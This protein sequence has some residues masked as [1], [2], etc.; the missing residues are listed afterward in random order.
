M[1]NNPQRAPTHKT[2]RSVKCKKLS[3]HPNQLPLT[4]PLS[5]ANGPS[6]NSGMKLLLQASLQRKWWR[7]QF[8]FRSHYDVSQE[9]LFVFSVCL[10]RL[11]TSALRF[12]CLFFHTTTFGSST[13]VFLDVSGAFTGSLST[14]F[15]LLAS[16]T[17]TLQAGRPGYTPRIHSEGD[18]SATST[19]PFHSCVVWGTRRQ[20]EPSIL[21]HLAF[22]FLANWFP[23]PSIHFRNALFRAPSACK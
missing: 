6:G 1:W 17:L 7:C 10:A 11:A 8:V 5:S 16:T 18:S 3:W 14:V 19:D 13:S 4:P 15:F 22:L 9:F 21:F 20:W 12:R 23:K 2:S